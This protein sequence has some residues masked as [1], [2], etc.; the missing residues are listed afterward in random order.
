MNNLNHEKIELINAHGPFNHSIWSDGKNIITQEER[1]SGRA[2]FLVNSVRSAILRQ[3]TLDE[4]SEMSIADVG[5]YDGWILHELSDLPFKRMVGIEPREKN[6]EKGKFIRKVLKVNNRVEFKCADFSIL[7]SENFD[8]ILCLGVFH[9]LESHTFAIDLL[10]QSAKK[11]IFIETICLSAVHQSKAFEIE[12]EMKDVVYRYKERIVGM[13]GQKFESAYYDGSAEKL[14]V[15][16]IPSINSLLM[17]LKLKFVNVKV[18]VDSETYRQ[19]FNNYDRNFQ[20]VC[21]SA[22]VDNETKYISNEFDWIKDYEKNMLETLLPLR[23]IE[24]LYNVVHNN[25]YNWNFKTFILYI[26]LFSRG[27]LSLVAKSLI[28]FIYKKEFEREIISNLKYSPSDKL[29]LEYGKILF[30]H[31]EYDRAIIVLKGITCKLNADWRSVYRS[32]YILFKIYSAL[33]LIE[34]AERYKN[35]LVISNQTAASTLLD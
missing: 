21:I 17:S 12:L 23:N 29:A 32:Y 18:E 33:D 31:K 5:C 28:N 10:R 2:D 24:T 11:F 13:S 26:H 35:L 7:N 19:A 22:L 20:A 3:F 25:S 16:N 15:V 27:T 9:H 34:E 6:I 1:L 8:I 14:S 30:D 4:I